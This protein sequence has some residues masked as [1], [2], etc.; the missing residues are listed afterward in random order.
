MDLRLVYDLLAGT[1]S[2][3]NNI[4]IYNLIEKQIILEIKTKGNLLLTCL[5]IFTII[6]NTT[7]T[8]KRLSMRHINALPILSTTGIIKASIQN[9]LANI[10]LTFIVAVGQ[11]NLN[12]AII[13]QIQISTLPILVILYLIQVEFLY[14]VF[15]QIVAVYPLPDRVLN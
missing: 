4:L 11:L 3:L 7:P 15:G 9:I 13:S 10:R 5:T 14:H 6:K 8:F 1:S 12:L 2:R